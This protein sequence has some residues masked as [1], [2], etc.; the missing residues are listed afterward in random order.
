[1][2]F[3]IVRLVLAIFFSYLAV[4]EG[5]VVGD[6]VYGLLFALI[7]IEYLGELVVLDKEDKL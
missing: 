3:S 5:L 2:M 6:R 1:M 4:Y 7:S